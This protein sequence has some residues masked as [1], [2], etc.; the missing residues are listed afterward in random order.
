MKRPAVTGP[1]G[2]YAAFLIIALIGTAAIL[3]V[4]KASTVAETS[5]QEVKKSDDIEYQ[6]KKLRESQEIRN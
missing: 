5:I 6:L 1:W 2:R 3:V 4:I